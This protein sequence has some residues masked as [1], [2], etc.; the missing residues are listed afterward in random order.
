M[1]IYA[2]V[3][4]DVATSAPGGCT[5]L[6]LRKASRRVS[7]IYD[8]SLEPLGL[9]VTQFSLLGHLN[10]FSGISI[11][12]LAAKMVMDPTTLTRN[13]RPLE[14]QGY[15]VF[16]AD[17]EDQR[18]RC[19]HLTA[20]GRKTYR[21]AKPAWTRAQRHVDKVLGDIGGPPL[22]DMLDRVLERLAT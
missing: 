5:C 21:D 7:Q 1:Q 2:P 14:K 11:G 19:L 13:L 8:Q 3:M 9:T 12:A 17:P 16:T 15:V 10:A 22:N 6:R 18:T 4:N 20:S